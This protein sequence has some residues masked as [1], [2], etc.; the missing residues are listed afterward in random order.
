MIIVFITAYHIVPNASIAVGHIGHK[1]TDY[2]TA[3][4]KDVNARSSTD[5]LGV[6]LPTIPP[7]LKINHRKGDDSYKDRTLLTNFGN[8]HFEAYRRAADEHN[9]RAGREELVISDIATDCWGRPLSE[10]HS[11]IH[12]LNRHADMNFYW[13]RRDY[14]MKALNIPMFSHAVVLKKT[15]K[16]VDNRETFVTY[17]SPKVNLDSYHLAVKLFN[18]KIGE[19]RMVL[20][21]SVERPGEHCLHDLKRRTEKLWDLSEFWKIH[22][23]VE[24]NKKNI[25]NSYA[26][27]VKKDRWTMLGSMPG[28]PS[29]ETNYFNVSGEDIDFYRRAVHNYNAIVGREIMVFDENAYDCNGNRY[30]GGRAVHCLAPHPYRQEVLEAFRAIAKS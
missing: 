18:A 19:T 28:K 30:V 14:W 1:I 16:P 20:S 13:N 6:V 8:S 5:C 24:A 7:L 23:T 4:K 10:G 2:S 26:L 9:K 11:S 25:Q 21:P 17:F 27:L 3:K 29:D 15:E 12:L 22:R